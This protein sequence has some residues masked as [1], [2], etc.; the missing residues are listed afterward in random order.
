M[1]K[2][3]T[4]DAREARL[5]QSG[6]DI[7]ILAGGPV[8]GF[9]PGVDRLKVSG[10][11]EASFRAAATQVGE[12]L[13]VALPEG[14]DLYIAWTTLGAFDLLVAETRPVRVAR[15]DQPKS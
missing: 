7:L 5:G 8:M 14:G 13:H 11:T 10:M 3:N 6:A 4:V 2:G 9:D 15:R 1:A 12:H